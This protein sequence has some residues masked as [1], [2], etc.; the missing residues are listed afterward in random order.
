LIP[1]ITRLD[2]S[3]AMDAAANEAIGRIERLTPLFSKGQATL[4]HGQDDVLRQLVTQT[5]ELARAAAAIGRTFRVALVG[6]TDADGG[7]EAN[8]PLSLSRAA[9]IKAALQ[10]VAGERLQFEDSGVGS[11]D[12]AVRSDREAEKQQNRRVT[13]KVTPAASTPPASGIGR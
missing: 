5:A 1:G 7:P 4:A 11:D 12:P 2:A 8:I 10:P 13:V 6:H 9:F 3:A